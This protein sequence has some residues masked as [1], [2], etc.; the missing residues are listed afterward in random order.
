MMEVM[1]FPFFKMRLDSWN[2]FHVHSTK[3]FQTS[4]TVSTPGEKE[5]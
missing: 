4:L 3:A 1:R 5:F 2:E